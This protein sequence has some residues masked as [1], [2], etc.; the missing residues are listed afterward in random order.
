MTAREGRRLAFRIAA[1][2]ARLVPGIVF[3]VAAAPKIADPPAFA[4]MIANYRLL[5]AALVHPAAL[6]LPWVELWSGIAL[7]T[8]F[9]AKTA[10]KLVAALLVVFLAAIG[11]NLARG[12]AVQCGC[13]DVHAA[14]KTREENLAQMRGVLFRDGLLLAA[15]VAFLRMKPVAESTDVEP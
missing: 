2:A 15:A 9:F 6:V 7:V 8:G 14:E 10:G 5:P 1:L 13:F 3:I 12:R 11:I 4:H